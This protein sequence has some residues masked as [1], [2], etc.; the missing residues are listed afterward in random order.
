MSNKFFVISPKDKLDVYYK[1]IVST[2]LFEWCFMINDAMKFETYEKAD[3]YSK[4][5]I[6]PIKTTIYEMERLMNTNEI[7]KKNAEDAY[8][9]AMGI[10]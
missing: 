8:D 6:Y 1:G 7:N 5:Y 2:G 10:V 3:A 9:R 4:T